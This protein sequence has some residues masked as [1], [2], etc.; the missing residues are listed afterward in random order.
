MKYKTVIASALMLCVSCLMGCMTSSAHDT[1][2]KF[3]VGTSLEYRTTTSQGPEV[4]A[5]DRID[6]LAGEPAQP[7]ATESGGD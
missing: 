4:V 2:R 6:M 5:W 7:D 3:Q 1:T